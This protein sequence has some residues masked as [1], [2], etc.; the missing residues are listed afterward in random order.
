MQ[1]KELE[2]VLEHEGLAPLPPAARA[3]L[4]ECSSC[5]S[6]L[7]DLATI[8]SLA[9]E[10][11]TEADPP[12]RLWISLRAQ[13]CAEGV[14]KESV[15]LPAGR[16]WW[17]GFAAWLRPRTL[18]TAGAGI[19]LFV[20]AVFLSRN[21]I[22]P[23]VD[24]VSSSPVSAPATSPVTSS[25]APRVAPPVGDSSLTPRP[26]PTEEAMANGG[27][28]LNQA[29][30]DVPNMQLAGN[31]T[32]DASLRDNLRT[33]NEFIAECQQHLKQHPGDQLAREYLES[34]YQQKAE[35]L[36]AMMDSGR[37]EH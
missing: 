25:V 2:A 33:V 5:Q 31:A 18:A 12:E 17:Q 35:L 7:A 32:V 14:I 22:P 28:V 1:C 19:V 29:E 20:T 16:P 34:A 8:Q 9:Q 30:L 26:S 36:A 11:P 15:E 13:L 24:R 37:S 10:L 21:P 6:F 27:V 3:H 23:P 4:A